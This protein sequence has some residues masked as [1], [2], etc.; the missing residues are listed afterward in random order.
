MEEGP[1]REKRELVVA[2]APLTCTKRPRVSNGYHRYG[3][4]IN[5]HTSYSEL[6][7]VLSAVTVLHFPLTPL[8][9]HSYIKS[10]PS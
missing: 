7:N 10:V 2:K 8:C 3:T 5:V 4:V 9:V 6:E 1:V